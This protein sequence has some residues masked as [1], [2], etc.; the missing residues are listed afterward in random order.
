MT[1]DSADEKLRA[2]FEK[3]SAM[4][5]IKKVLNGVLTLFGVGA[6]L[7]GWYVKK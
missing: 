6:S 1:S 5:L 4:Q 7:K 3:N 2:G